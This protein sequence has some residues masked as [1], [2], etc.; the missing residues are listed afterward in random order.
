MG[1]QKELGRTENGNVER[2]VDDIKDL[3]GLYSDGE[4]DAIGRKIETQIKYENSV[5][6]PYI[7]KKLSLKRYHDD[8]HPTFTSGD[9]LMRLTARGW[10]PGYN[11]KCYLPGEKDEKKGKQ[12]KKRFKKLSFQEQLKVVGYFAS[13]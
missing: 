1:S 5:S 8:D 4:F 12:L 13:L 10:L 6:A 2:V 9:E 7:I 3:L 11:L